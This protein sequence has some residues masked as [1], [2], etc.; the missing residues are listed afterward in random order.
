MRG[1]LTNRF[2]KTIRAVIL[3]RYGSGEYIVP[4][5]RWVKT[6]EWLDVDKCFVAFD[7]DNYTLYDCRIISP[8]D[9]HWYDCITAM[10]GDAYPPIDSGASSFSEL[11]VMGNRENLGNDSDEGGP[12]PVTSGPGDTE[13]NQ[14]GTNPY[15]EDSTEPRRKKPIVPAARRRTRKKETK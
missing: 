9:G 1:I 13:D 3:S 5:G 8:R 11:P 2:H 14:G 7:F 6:G 4:A 10:P 12:N 15:S